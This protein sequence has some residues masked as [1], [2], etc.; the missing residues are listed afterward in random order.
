MLPET[1][2]LTIP[3]V[4]K[5]IIH[6]VPVKI[7]TKCVDCFDFYNR[8]YG[9]PN[10]F[11]ENKDNMKSGIT[12]VNE[13][14][15]SIGFTLTGHDELEPNASTNSE[16]IEAGLKLK[17]AGFKTYCS[18]EPVIDFES[19]HRMINNSDGVFDLYK[20][21]L[22]SGKKY[23]KEALNLFIDWVIEHTN[24]NA[25]IYFKDSLLQQ[26]GVNRKDLPENCVGRDYNLFTN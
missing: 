2:D 11:I 7:L 16:R 1:V 9:E 4:S 5:C 8:F 24:K 14:K 20:I 25:K 19:S 10:V 23:D 12:L 26:V 18:L 17:E 6:D 21:G 15:I 13:H 3:A 22:K